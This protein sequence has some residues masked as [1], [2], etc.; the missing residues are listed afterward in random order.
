M[1]TRV[2]ACLLVAF[3]GALAAPLPVQVCAALDPIFADGAE[4]PCPGCREWIVAEGGADAGL[5]T[6]ASPLRT[7]QAAVET[8]RPG[9]RIVVL[10]GT[11]AGVRIGQSHSGT[12]ARPLTLRAEGQVV[13][14]R[15]LEGYRDNVEINGADYVRI[16]GFRV[17]DAERAGIAVLES[18]GSVVM[19]NDVGPN[20]RWGV[21]TGF[22]TDF[23]VL[24]NRTYDSGTEHGIYISNSRVVDDNV[25]VLGNESFGNG[26]S[27]I[28]F[29]GDCYTSCPAGDP[30]QCTAGEGLIG[31]SLIGHNRVYGNATKGLSIISVDRTV[32]FNNLIYGNL[33]GAASVHLT[34]EPGCGLPSRRTSV[35]NN[36]MVEPQIAPVRITD[37]AFDNVVFNNIAVR[38]GRLDALVDEVGGNSLDAVT[39]IVRASAEGLF[40]DG[41]SYLPAEDSPA[42]DAG[43]PTFLGQSAPACDLRHVSR[44]PGGAPDAGAIESREVFA[45]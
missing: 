26:R 21:F 20:G 14:D 25:W 24:F 45:P 15:G 17:R 9:D 34:D 19:A 3:G 4:D 2:F 16:V 10:P 6:R 7:I 28:Q 18:T 41:Q 44:P 5:G 43:A 1:A 13:I 23:K 32:I 8:A 30:G 29:N 42:L 38:E 31:H 11:Y 33:G 22:A 35:V 27:G 40:R 12:L 37:A 39:N 36:T